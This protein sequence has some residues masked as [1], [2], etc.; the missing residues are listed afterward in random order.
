MSVR[1]SFYSPLII[2]FTV[3][4]NFKP[5]FATLFLRRPGWSAKKASTHEQDGVSTSSKVPAFKGVPGS[6]R[7]DASSGPTSSKSPWR[8]TTTDH[9]QDVAERVS[10][11]TPALLVHVTV[12]RKMVISPITTR[13]PKSQRSAVDQFRPFSL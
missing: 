9:A 13:G 12:A 6:T 8:L 4:D 5:F 7:G 3:A 2:K 10:Q 11:D 1:A